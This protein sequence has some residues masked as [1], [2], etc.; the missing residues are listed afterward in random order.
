M[1]PPVEARVATTLA[2]WVSRVFHPFIVSTPILFL[3]QVFSGVTALEAFGWTGLSVAV[4]ILPTLLFV[5][6]GIRTG[7][8]K[9]IDVSVREDRHLLYGIAGVCFVLV[10]ILLAV[11]GAPEITRETLQAALCAFVVAAVLNRFV[12]KVSLH[13]L[14]MGGSTAVLAFVLVPLAVGLGLLGLPVG[15]SRLHLTRH[16]LFETVLGW[17][18]GFICFAAWLLIARG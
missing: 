2:V 14:V 16:T 5:L 9:D 7:R 12:G 3:A 8:Y 1:Q 10:I 15:W 11:L 17:A 6:V 4:L 13:M 18:V